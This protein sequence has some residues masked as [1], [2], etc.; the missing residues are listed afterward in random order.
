MVMVA[1]EVQV[2]E[3]EQTVAQVEQEHQL[4]LNQLMS[5]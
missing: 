1:M 2:E 3:Q 5:K 4:I